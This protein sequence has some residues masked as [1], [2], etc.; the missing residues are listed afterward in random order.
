M[1]S[2][3][4]THDPAVKHTIIV[5]Q[6]VGSI[7]QN[8]AEW[9]A[10]H[11]SDS[12]ARVPFDHAPMIGHDLRLRPYRS[13]D[14]PF[15]QA[16][17]ATTRADEMAFA[18]W[19]EEQKAAFLRQQLGARETHYAAEFP[20]AANDIVTVAGRDAGRLLVDRSGGELRVVDIALL[21]DYRGQ[22]I[23]T[24]LMTR[25]MA[26]AAELGVPVRLHADPHGRARGLYLRLGFTSVSS[27]GVY[28]LM[29]RLP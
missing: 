16:L 12:V 21:P 27:D 11:R 5:Q 22:G 29:E 14:L 24:A 2:Q 23:G 19:P 6:E 20:A 26:D 9:A 3:P 1:A 7:A 13:T 10:G 4:S 25:L 17:Y 15:L 8:P 28:E 18:P